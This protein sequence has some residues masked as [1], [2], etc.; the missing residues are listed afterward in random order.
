MFGICLS[1]FQRSILFSALTLCVSLPLAQLPAFQPLPATGPKSEVKAGEKE[2]APKN[3][4]PKV[5]DVDRMVAFSLSLGDD[6]QARV[7]F[8]GMKDAA[9]MVEIAANDQIQKYLV[10]EFGAAEPPQGVVIRVASNVKYPMVDALYGTIRSVL[11]EN[12][13]RR[14]VYISV[15]QPVAQ[16]DDDEV[17][18]QEFICQNRKAENLYDRVVSVAKVLDV[19]V[20]LDPARNSITAKGPSRKVTAIQNLINYLDKSEGAA[21]DA[22]PRNAANPP[23]TPRVDQPTETETSPETLPAERQETPAVPPLANAPD[24]GAA[25]PTIPVPGDGAAAAGIGRYQLTGVGSNLFLLD[26][27]SG[28]IWY[29]DAAGETMGWIKLPSPWNQR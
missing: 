29:L 17:R 15:E 25:A 20:R 3:Q 18:T 16:Q 8:R 4:P 24:R 12:Q 2:L 13:I 11:D 6:N 22:T 19:S 14:P 7:R 27:A 26:T 10:P 21:P 28:D 23:S 5:V 9:E 1:G